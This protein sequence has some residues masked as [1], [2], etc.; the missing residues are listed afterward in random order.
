MK[1]NIAFI[2]DD[3]SYAYADELTPYELYQQRQPRKRAKLEHLNEEEK[4]L[5]RKILNREAAQKARDRKKDLIDY[6]EQ[7]IAQLTTENQMLRSA[8]RSL[9]QSFQAQEVKIGRLE[10]QFSTVLKQLE[11]S[12][13]IVSV[14]GFPLTLKPDP[15][16]QRISQTCTRRKTQFRPIAP[17]I[18]LQPQK[19]LAPQT[20]PEMA[21]IVTVEAD[22]LCCDAFL[23]SDQP[24]AARLDDIFESLNED[25]SLISFE[26]DQ[27]LP[28]PD[29]DLDSIFSDSSQFY[30][31]NLIHPFIM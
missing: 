21:E 24:D 25:N 10:K 17:K 1:R 2:P 29:L 22:P 12:G 19:I 4:A 23:R 13:E 3:Y 26:E 11:G 31:D 14:E 16:S 15:N 20:R 18:T 8:N 6:M 28:L 5:R 30:S 7:S 9:K 27:L